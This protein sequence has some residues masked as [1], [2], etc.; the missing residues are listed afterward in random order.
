MNEMW[1]VA[2][3]EIVERVKDRGFLLSS[4]VSVLFV[5]GVIFVPRLLGSGDPTE[6]AVGVVGAA[7]QD[8]VE[9][10][11]AQAPAFDAEV[12][13]S[14]FE[15][16][17]A[18]RAAVAAEELDVAVVDG[19]E[20]LVRE[21]LPED[22]GTLLQAASAEVQARARLETAG[23]PPAEIDTVLHPAP[24][25]VTV[26]EPPDP[27]ASDDAAGLA[28]LVSFILFGQVFGYGMWVANGVV[29][30]KSTRVVEVLLARIRPQRLLAGKI[31][32]IGLLGLLQLAVIAG[33]SL[34]VALAAGTV[35]IPPGTV[36]AVAASLVW[37]VLGYAL[38]ACLFGMAGALV[39][40]QEEL[41]NSIG[42]MMLVFFA[43]IGL[44]IAAITDPGSTL[45]RVASF[46]PTAAPVVMPVRIALGEASFVDV[47][48]SV[49][50]TLA[51]IAAVV[52]LAARVYRRSVLHTGAPISLRR[53]LRVG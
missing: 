36:S 47:A 22:L 14:R 39:T 42:P 11:A 5:L 41:Q 16:V 12:Q 10:A 17:Q 4:L 50:V 15:S 35:D 24:L 29:E 27:S 30:E 7:S 1:I 49:L 48:G 23:L 25:P 45:S 13:V 6:H 2:R 3:R 46:I 28:G 9:A 18:A 38:F 19:R 43:S 31:L 44:S 40:R 53:A 52:P 20:L 26:L 33:I 37:F 34:G 51:A 32:G 8:L 21:E